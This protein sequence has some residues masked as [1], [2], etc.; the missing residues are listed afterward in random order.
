[1]AVPMAFRRVFRML[2]ALAVLIAL[3]VP[4]RGQDGRPLTGVALVIG[5]SRYEHL[6]PLA[7]PAADADALSGVL[8]AL[9]FE[10]TV[11]RDLNGR[12]LKRALD[13]FVEDA[14]GADVAVVYFSGHGI[15]AGGENWLVPVD[16][17]STSLDSATGRLAGVSNLIQSLSQGTPLTI[18]FLDA[19]RTNPFPPGSLFR[20]ADGSTSAVGAAGL[21]ITRGAV[22]ARVASADPTFGSVVGFATEPGRP[23]LDGPAGG[24]SPYAAAL[25]RHLSA[26]DGTEFGTV[27]RMVT[28][29]VYLRT[30]GAQRPWVN[31]SLTRLVYMGTQPQDPPGDEGRILGER[32]QLLI[33][34]TALAPEQREQVETASRMAGVPM[35]ALYGLLRSL[36]TSVPSDPE[37]LSRLLDAQAGRVR[38]LIAQ[39]QG[40]ASADPEIARLTRLAEEALQ[41][42]ALDTYVLLWERAKARYEETAKTLDEAEAQL[43]ARRIEGGAVLAST[44]AAHELTADYQKAARGFRAAFE[45]VEKW[46]ADKAAEYKRREA[47]AWLSFGD[48]SG[49]ARALET[50]IAAFNAALAMTPR[51]AVPLGWALIQNNLGNAFLVRGRGEAGTQ[52]IEAA[53][54]AYHAALEIRTRGTQPQLWAKTENNLALALMELNERSGD[55]ALLDQAI[56]SYRAALSVI[57]RTSE[58]SAW[59]AVASNLGNALERKGGAALDEAVS[60]HRSVLEARP[61]ARVPVMWAGSQEN[62]GNALVSSGKFRADAAL[63]REGLAAYGQALEVIAREGQPLRWAGLNYNRGNGFSALAEIDPSVDNMRAAVAAYRTALLEERFDRTPAS[64]GKTQY[65]L[66]EALWTLGEAADDMEARKAAVAALMESLRFYSRQSNMRDWAATLIQAGRKQHRLGVLT[67]DGAALDRGAAML[68]QPLDYFTRERD[69][70]EWA[71]AASLYA[72]ALT[73]SAFINGATT[74]LDDAVALWRRVVEVHRR[75]TAPLDWAADQLSLAGALYYSAVLKNDDGPAREGRESAAAAAAIFR[76][77][78]DGQRADAAAALLEQFDALI[79]Q[80]PP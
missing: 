67:Q 10:T 75:D 76:E 25:A 78:N 80:L 79:S 15:E 35:D 70:G 12:K 66:G 54:R 36:G 62:L 48:V 22:E 59:A 8:E 2:A 50:A 6:P 24:N 28:E 33:A 7:N 16:A 34:M 1:M 26:M 14:E 21:G 52:S 4:A 42:G 45:Q 31:E 47:D 55:P 73:D 3:A 63:I 32:R 38:D 71:D 20:Q 69:P 77:Q 68:R 37:E 19:C 74:A 49:E 9:G 29:E 56:A 27:M 72:A 11:L 13:N 5:Q 23:A 57:D 30:Q 40:L 51:D 53:V 46:D 61:R 39:S 58:P 64:W 43:K 17:D 41:D 65:M 60:L 44:A 18:V